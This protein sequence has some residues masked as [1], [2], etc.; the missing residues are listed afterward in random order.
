MEILSK[1]I[2][3]SKLSGMCDRSQ[4]DLSLGFQITGCLVYS[5]LIV[6]EKI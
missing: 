2:T 5:R 6:Q 3:T 4:D 1:T